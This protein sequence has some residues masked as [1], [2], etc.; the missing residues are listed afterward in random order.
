MPEFDE[1]ETEAE[2]EEGESEPEL[3]GPEREPAPVAQLGLF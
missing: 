2:G 1:L 3:A